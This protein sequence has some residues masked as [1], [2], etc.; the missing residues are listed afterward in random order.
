MAESIKQRISELKISNG[1]KGYITKLL[2]K[3]QEVKNA[4]II[5]FNN[6]YTF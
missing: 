6:R 5:Y 3:V 4:K 1:R 2:K